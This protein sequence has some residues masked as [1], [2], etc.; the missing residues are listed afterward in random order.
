MCL[1]ATGTLQRLM[2]MARQ[3]A[4]LQALSKAG[5]VQQVWQ[6]AATISATCQVCLA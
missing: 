3:Y 1:P 5:A 4:V 2:T 6:E